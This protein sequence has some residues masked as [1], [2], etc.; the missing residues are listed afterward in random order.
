M[1]EEFFERAK[2]LAAFG[3]EH[4]I[5]VMI[6]ARDE[7]G[8]ISAQEH[9]RSP[10]STPICYRFFEVASCRTKLVD[11]ML[12]LRDCFCEAAQA[13]LHCPDRKGHSIKIENYEDAL[14]KTRS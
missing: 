14:L 10:D 3:L 7:W 2:T 5:D 13:Y 6:V 8:N 11:A 1:K 12:L 4:G 9:Y